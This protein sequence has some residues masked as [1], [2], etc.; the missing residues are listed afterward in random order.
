MLMTKTSRTFGGQEQLEALAIFKSM[1]VF[2]S[3]GIVYVFLEDHSRSTLFRSYI[4][5][6]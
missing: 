1:M 4:Q 5:E 2:Y 3:L 6:D